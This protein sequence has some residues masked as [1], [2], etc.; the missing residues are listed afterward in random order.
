MIV[1]ATVGVAALVGI[2]TVAYVRRR[3]KQA[4]VQRELQARLDATC[5]RG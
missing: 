3:L 1:P 5:I 2:V 4:R